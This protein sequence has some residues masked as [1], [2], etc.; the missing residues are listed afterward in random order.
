ML[1]LLPVLA[2][3]LAPMCRAA[4]NLTECEKRNETAADSTLIFVFNCMSSV[5]SLIGVAANILNMVIL[6]RSWM[7]SSTNV[8]LTV[9]S[10]CDTLHLSAY[11]LFLLLRTKQDFNLKTLSFFVLRCSSYFSNATVWL[12]TTFT[13]ER[14]IAVTKPILSQRFCTVGKARLASFVNLLISLLLT[15]PSFFEFK[16]MPCRVLDPKTRSYMKRFEPKHTVFFKS[17][18]Y[19][20]ELFMAVMFLALPLVLL[21]VFNSLLIF[22]VV[23]ATENRKFLMRNQNSY[24]LHTGGVLLTS[25]SVPR[26]PLRKASDGK[27]QFA[28]P[29]LNRKPVVTEQQRITIMLIAVVMSFVLFLTPSAVNT[30]MN[31]KLKNFSMAANFLVLFNSTLNFVFYSLF[32]VKFRHTF[33]LLIG[34]PMTTTLCLIR[35]K[36]QTRFG[37]R[38]CVS[39]CTRRSESSQVEPVVKDGTNG[40]LDPGPETPKMKKNLSRALLQRHS[41]R[42]GQRLASSNQSVAHT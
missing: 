30:L 38:C 32:S 17:I 31:T 33:K 4:E 41:K 21:I 16:F 29:V 24:G 3:L 18:G 35:E 12:T 14:F 15:L 26:I 19:Y 23:K 37:D 22:S 28:K 27:T 34:K 36:V 2:L 7:K 25:G 1:R 20:Y 5:V 42:A 39:N 6:T 8:Y 13:I 9:V 11:L 40:F 10:A